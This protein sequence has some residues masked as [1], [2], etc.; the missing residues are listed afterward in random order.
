[1]DPEPRRPPVTYDERPCKS[2]LNAVKGMPF[3]WSLNP[4]TGCEHRCT[5]CYVRAFERR[6]DRP[7]GDAYGRSIRV[8]V[9][10]AQVLR[11]ELAR[12]TWGREPVAIGAATDPYQPAEGR[13]RLT[14]GCLAVF[15]SAASPANLITRGPMVVRDVD[16]LSDLARRAEVSIT[17][18]VPTLD[19]DVWRRS[20][21]GTA[22]P[23]QRLRAL[24]RLAAAGIRCGVSMAPILPGLSDRPEQLEEVV[25]AARE[26]GAR[27]VWSNLLYL[28]DGT[29]EHFLAS[30]ERYWPELVG[31][32]RRDYA[33]RAYLP[34]SMTTPVQDRVAA[35]WAATAPD[36]PP[37]PVIRPAPPPQQL[38]L[39]PG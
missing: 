31:R 3:R 1:V 13:F 21:P 17:F 39:L 24:E 38:S 23:R 16:V 11:A 28:R 25:R 26:S 36:A 9:N 8:K 19:H 2:A 20:E 6:A 37:R 5:F 34:S 35:M 32:Y 29:R 18:S 14:R 33:G 4:Y 10:I 15:A 7:S 12:P 30:V 22:P 27:Y